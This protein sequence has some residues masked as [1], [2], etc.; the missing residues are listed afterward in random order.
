MMKLKELPRAADVK[1]KIIGIGGAGCSSLNRLTDTVSNNVR[2]LGIDTGSA[3]AHLN[4]GVEALSIGNGFGSGGNPETAV[5]LFSEYESRVVDFIDGADVVILLAGLGRGTGS[6]LAPEIARITRKSGALTIAA[7]NMPFEFEGRFRNQSAARAHE[8]LESSADAVMTMYNDDLLAGGVMGGSLNDA[9]VNADMN[10]AAAVNAVTL[11]LE[12]SPE[13]ALSVQDSLTNA[14]E[15]AV[16]SGASTGLHAGSKAVVEAFTYTSSE[17][18]G[19][20][21][22]V[23]HVLGGIGLSHGQVA[24][25]VDKVREEIGMSAIIHVSSERLIGMGQEIN[26]TI[27]LA[28]IGG[29]PS[30]EKKFTPFIPMQRDMANAQVMSVFDTP[31]PRR[32]RGP[33]LLPTG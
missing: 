30:S 28:G 31:V 14:G 3:A 2:M 19:V 26:V 20:R 15:L 29:E 23:V 21:S 27:V 32:T 4:D 24:D 33:V 8:L 6:G 11:A 18:V 9:F 17:F 22:A 7:V 5:D 13:R 10:I 12:S 16:I 25:A 1:V